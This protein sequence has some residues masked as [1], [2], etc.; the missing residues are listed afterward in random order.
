MIA[1]DEVR[2]DIPLR[3]GAWHRALVEYSAKLREK[4]QIIIPV[5]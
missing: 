4:L 5:L 2:T 3:T 1:G